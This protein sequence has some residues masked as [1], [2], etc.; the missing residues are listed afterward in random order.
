MV[1]PDA[2]KVKTH[3]FS[4]YDPDNVYRSFEL[5][6]GLPF[7]IYVRIKRS[8]SVKDELEIF[9]SDVNKET[10][11]NGKKIRYAILDTVRFSAALLTGVEFYD[12]EDANGGTQAR[13]LPILDELNGGLADCV[14]S[15]RKGDN[16]DIVEQLVRQLDLFEYAATKEGR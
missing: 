15:A 9:L 3:D 10:D 8:I 12:H 7:D 2:F 1:N 11:D 6:A 13:F 5:I 16:E 14:K 4:E